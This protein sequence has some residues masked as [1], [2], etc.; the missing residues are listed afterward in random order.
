MKQNAW[1]IILGVILV[2][3]GALALLQNFTGLEFQGTWW[4]LLF[5]LIF[6]GAGVGFLTTLL[7]DRRANWWA[8][9]PGC[10]LVGLGIIILLGALN[11]RPSELLGAIFMAAISASFWV[12]YLLDR[13]KWWAIIPGGVLL[14]LAVMIAI[15]ND[16]G[17]WPAV[18][19]FGGMAVTFGIVAVLG[20]PGARPRTWAW[21]P[22]GAMVV[23]ALLIATTAGPLPGLIWPILLIGAG[24]VMVAW[25]L[26]ARRS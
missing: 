8:A 13:A 22:A 20:E 6:A 9:I 14:S 5:A 18:I 25:T 16:S 1:R 23:L 24:L 19:L 2:L 15:A 3:F 7:A 4:G 12:V 26:V 17:S 21:Y 10:T 11:F